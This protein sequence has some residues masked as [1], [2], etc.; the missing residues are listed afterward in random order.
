MSW[1]ILY[2]F[3]ILLGDIVMENSEDYVVSE[4]EKT[5][6]KL[7]DISQA[8]D[9]QNQILRLIV[10]VS[11]MLHNYDFVYFIFVSIKLIYY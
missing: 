6:K 11:I 2:L 4:L 8:I 1:N 10:Q 7:K 5:K 9:T 3:N